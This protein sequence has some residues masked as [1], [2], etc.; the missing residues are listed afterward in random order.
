MGETGRD[1]VEGQSEVNS[2][3]E[4]LEAT[5][6]RLERHIDRLPEKLSA[7]LRPPV[8]SGDDKSKEAVALT[9]LAG[10]IRS[11]NDRVV[12]MEDKTKVLLDNIEL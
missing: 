12:T 10:R 1:A 5:I 8:P 2:Q 7:V 6:E 11:F 9:P 4:S 3:M